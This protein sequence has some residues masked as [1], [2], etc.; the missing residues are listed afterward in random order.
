ME[1]AAGSTRGTPI[2]EVNVYFN[3]F[4]L[5]VAITIL[6]PDNFYSSYK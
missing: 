5:V 6:K 1:L 4:F 2:R 3:L